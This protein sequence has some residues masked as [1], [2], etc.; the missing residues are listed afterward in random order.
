MVKTK[1]QKRPRQTKAGRKK[2]YLS[3]ADLLIELNNCIEL[4]KTTNKICEYFHAMAK[5]ISHKYSYRRYYNEIDDMIQEAVINCLKGVNKFTGEKYK[6]PNPF[7]YFT[8][9]II[10]SFNLFLKKKYKYDNFKMEIVEEYYKEKNMPFLNMIKDD[11]IK[12]KKKKY[13]KD[14]DDEG[15]ETV[16]QYVDIE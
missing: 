10:N 9:T 11:I 8:T 13:A 2:N 6:N 12:S 14:E 16:S 1:K 4:D 5:N 3:N 15:I 7:S